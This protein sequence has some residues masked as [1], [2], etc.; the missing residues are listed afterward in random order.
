MRDN[1]MI[2]LFQP[3][4]RN[5]AR[6]RTVAVA[7]CMKARKTYFKGEGGSIVRRGL[8]NFVNLS[9]FLRFARKIRLEI[10]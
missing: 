10:A 6:Q 8:S 3:H 4:S 2:L 7:I 9:S 1:S 5:L